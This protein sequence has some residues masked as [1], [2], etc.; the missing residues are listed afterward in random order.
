MPAAAGRARCIPLFQLIQ[1]PAPLGAI[2][3]PG[4]DKLTAEACYWSG[5]AAQG[6]S[7][8]GTYDGVAKVDGTWNTAVEAMNKAL[9]GTK[10]TYRYGI[11][12]STP[13]LGPDSGAK[14]LAR[15]FNLTWPL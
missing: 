12:G 3:N 7:G 10:C 9:E 13:T 6:V 14:A 1:P 5:G 8:S 2:Q 15:L 11:T 4:K